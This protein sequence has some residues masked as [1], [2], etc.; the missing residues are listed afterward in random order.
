[1]S[2]RSAQISHKT[3]SR[4]NFVAKLD[5]VGKVCLW[6]EP[7]FGRR[8]FFFEPGGHRSGIPQTKGKRVVKL[9]QRFRRPV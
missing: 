2:H 4:Y 7:A 8:V 5:S 3:G 6:W 1:M 9:L